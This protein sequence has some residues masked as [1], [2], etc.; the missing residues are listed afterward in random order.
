MKNV[1]I[2]EATRYTAY[3]YP[4]NVVISTKYQSFRITKPNRH[5][6]NHLDELTLKI[7]KGDVKCVADIRD[8]N[9]EL[10]WTNCNRPSIS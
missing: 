4:K 5:T 9:G 6:I 2:Y 7:I 1:G 3:I 10:K 8:Y